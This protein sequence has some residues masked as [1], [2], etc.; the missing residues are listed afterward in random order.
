MTR[1]QDPKLIGK[2]R[3]LQLLDRDTWEYV[4]RFAAKG[5]VDIVAVT[6]DEKLV[7]VEQFRP[8][9]AAP[10]IELPAGLI[11]DETDIVEED[12]SEAARRELLEE[13]GYAAGRLNL[14]ATG[15]AAPGHSTENVSIFLA[16]DLTKVTEGGG[17]EDEDIRVHE[18]QIPEADAWIT[19]QKARGAEMSLRVYLG[20]YFAQ[21]FLAAN[22]R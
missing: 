5:V 6:H 15:Y 22:P 16:T 7:L 4:D 2:G 14:V 21:Q 11:G 18:V 10:V 3:F 13:T 9:A 19:S 17:V 12:A 20:L 8:A 1:D